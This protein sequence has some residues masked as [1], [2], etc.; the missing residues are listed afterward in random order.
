MYINVESF[1]C[2]D[3]LSLELPWKLQICNLAWCQ[4]HIPNSVSP[5]ALKVK[6]RPPNIF[7]CQLRLWT[8][9]FDT[10]TEEERNAF[11]TSL[12]EK[13][14][15]FVAQFYKGLASTA[16]RDW[17]SWISNF[18]NHVSIMPRSW[19]VHS[20]LPFLLDKEIF[21]KSISIYQ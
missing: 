1:N 19:T 10:W 6:D 17:W 4:L 5:S 15:V 18:F 20:T 21:C 16:G 13:D 14:P 2:N 7:E 12:E 11:L 8:Q 3:L 9:W